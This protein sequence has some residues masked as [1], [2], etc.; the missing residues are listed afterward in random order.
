VKVQKICARIVLQPYVS[1]SKSGRKAA[2]FP[3]VE[4]IIENYYYLD[5]P[6]KAII[7]GT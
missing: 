1:Q 4:V 5:W 7:S 3:S 2:F 6:S